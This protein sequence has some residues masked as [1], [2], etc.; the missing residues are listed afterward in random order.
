MSKGARVG[1]TDEQQERLDI[2]QAAFRAAA[3]R[4]TDDVL[5]QYL[6][7]EIA[8]FIEL[9][10]DPDDWTWEEEDDIREEL[11]A[12]FEGW[13]P[14]PTKIIDQAVEGIMALPYNEA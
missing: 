13:N 7:Y 14:Q 6:A 9:R 5:W 2:Q 11:A 1:I 8:E 10:A 3:S 4:I 12:N